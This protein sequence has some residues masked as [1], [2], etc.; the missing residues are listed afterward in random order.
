MVISSFFLSIVAEAFK[1]GSNVVLSK[2]SNDNTM[3]VNGTVVPQKN[4]SY[5]VLYA[6]FGLSEGNSRK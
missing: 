6:G 4:E 3:A 1:I 5:L 2:W